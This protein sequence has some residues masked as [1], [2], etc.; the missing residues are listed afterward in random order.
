[1]ELKIDG[2]VL[3]EKD[4]L[5][6]VIILLLHNHSGILRAFISILSRRIG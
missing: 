2:I 3:F 4:R 1:L 6:T 5:I